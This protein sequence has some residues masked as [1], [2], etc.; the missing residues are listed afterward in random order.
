M[1]AKRGTK[2]PRKPVPETAA[3]ASLTEYLAPIGD[4]K[5][6]PRVY[7]MSAGK[8]WGSHQRWCSLD[9]DHTGPCISKNIPMSDE[10]NAKFPAQPV[11]GS[12]WT[13]DM[14]DAMNYSI[15]YNP[16][17]P[18]GS[19]TGR[20]T[21]ERVAD[22]SRE[23]EKATQDRINKL[24][25]AIVVGKAVHGHPYTGKATE[26]LSLAFAVLHDRDIVNNLTEFVKLESTPSRLMWDTLL[27][28]A[29]NVSSSVKYY[30]LPET[31]PN[32][33]MAEEI[34]QVQRAIVAVCGSEPSKYDYVPVPGN[35]KAIV[36]FAQNLIGKWVFPMK[37]LE[38][39]QQKAEVE[40]IMQATKQKMKVEVNSVPPIVALGRCIYRGRF[41]SSHQGEHAKQVTCWQWKAI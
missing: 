1:S 5:P 28:K 22:L 39:L 30:N 11:A 10:M 2:K 41:G 35:W 17:K 15:G 7:Y 6:E 16:G 26:Y 20:W 4:V 19:R 27:Q 40:E 38:D 14:V 25:D 3:K 31:H 29:T 36:A 34:L 24:Y 23:S 33:K 9:L 13:P 21:A 8:P 32:V 18:S 37:D 12:S